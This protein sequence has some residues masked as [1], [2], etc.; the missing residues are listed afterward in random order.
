M[1]LNLTQHAPTPEQVAAGVVEPK[2]EVKAAIVAALTFDSL[3]SREE[4]GARA[5]DLAE[6]ACRYDI[7][8]TDDDIGEEFPGAAMIGGAPYLMAALERELSARGVRPLYAFSTRESVEQTQPDGSV[9]KIN[10]FRHIG[11]VDVAGF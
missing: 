1:I 4:I 3:P 8:D 6:I 10:V 9:R 7:A 11:F 2:P 5:A